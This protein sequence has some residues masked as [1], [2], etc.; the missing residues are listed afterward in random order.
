MRRTTFLTGVAAGFVLGSRCGR[1]PYEL[2]AANVKWL[3][4]RRQVQLAADRVRSAAG[5]RLHAADRALGARVPAWQG[6][7]RRV[8][9]T[10]PAPGPMAPGSTPDTGYADAQDLEFGA[11]AA[12]KAQALDAQL[13]RGASFDEMVA[14]ERALLVTGD[15]VPPSRA[16]QQELA[17]GTSKRHKLR[18]QVTPK[19]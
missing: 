6:L 18:K 2:L 5:D 16:D 14:R 13:E 15:L 11:S 9:R 7:T 3:R 17:D 1:E 19:G 10:A 4:R 12:R 8:V